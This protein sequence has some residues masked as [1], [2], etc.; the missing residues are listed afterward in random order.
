MSVRRSKT[1]TKPHGEPANSGSTRLLVAQRSLLVFGVLLSYACAAH[2]INDLLSRHANRRIPVLRKRYWR[3][4]SATTLLM[5]IAKHLPATE[6]LCI[7]VVAKTRP[8]LTDCLQVVE[9]Y[10][11]L[12]SFDHTEASDPVKKMLLSNPPIERPSEA[13]STREFGSRSRSYS[14]SILFSDQFKNFAVRVRDVNS[15]YK[16]TDNDAV[17]YAFTSSAVRETYRSLSI[18]KTRNVFRGKA[19]EHESMVR[20]YCAHY[21][22]RRPRLKI[23]W[24]PSICKWQCSNFSSCDKAIARNEA[25]AR[26]AKKVA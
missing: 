4:R 26:L 3:I 20:R 25:R 22:R 6:L 14:T 17:R 13:L 12:I 21:K 7:N 1:K 18:E 10:H 16:S 8:R 11:H 5:K 23:E 19:L 2:L 24:H 9:R 15:K